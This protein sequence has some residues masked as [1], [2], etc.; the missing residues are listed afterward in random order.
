[1]VV[2]FFDIVTIETSVCLTCLN[3]SFSKKSISSHSRHIR[4]SKSIKLEVLISF[5]VHESQMSIPHRGE[6]TSVY[7]ISKIKHPPRNSNVCKF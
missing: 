5:P 1:M 3:T 6:L 2:S 4:P 7:L